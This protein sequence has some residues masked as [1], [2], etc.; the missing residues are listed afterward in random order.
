MREW[1]CNVIFQPNND[2]FVFV[3]WEELDFRIR[4]SFMQL[5]DHQITK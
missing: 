2:G 1:L 5:S 4:F 3:N